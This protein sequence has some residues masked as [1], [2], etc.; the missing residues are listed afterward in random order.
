MKISSINLLAT[1]EVTIEDG[2][3]SSS[4]LVFYNSESEKIIIVDNM[5]EDKKSQIERH[6]AEYLKDEDLGLET[7]FDTDLSDSIR[8]AREKSRST[9]AYASESR[10]AIKIKKN[11]ENG[12]HNV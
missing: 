10:E 9:Q 7:S 1:F 11:K 4:H 12:D 5:D 2:E 6:I 8:R 3:K